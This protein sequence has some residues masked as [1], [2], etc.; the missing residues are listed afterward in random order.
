MTLTDLHD[1]MWRYN[2][3]VAYAGECNAWQEFVA[4]SY[5][6]LGRAPW[7]DNHDG[8]VPGDFAEYWSEVAKG[9]S[10]QFDANTGA[11]PFDTADEWR[12]F[13]EADA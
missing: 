12:D 2:Q 11:G 10:E 4:A 1:A 6:E 7:D 13:R 8:D 3:S 5:R 9:A